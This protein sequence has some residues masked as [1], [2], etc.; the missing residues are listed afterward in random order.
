VDEETSM[1]IQILSDTH[2]EFHEDEGKEFV[3]NLPVVG[4][5]LVV[6]GDFSMVGQLV[7]RLTELCA[8]FPHVV[9]VA[10]NHEYYHTRGRDE[11]NKALGKVGRRC[12]NFTWLNNTSA[13]IQGRRFV[14]T[15]MW[16]PHHPLN[17]CHEHLLADFKYIRGYRKWVYDANDRAKAFLE[18]EV[19]PGDIVVTHHV[20]SYACIDGRFRGDDANR[21]YVS[22]WA[23]RIIYEQEPELWVFGHSHARTD[24][25][26]E[27]THLVSN[28]FGYKGRSEVREFD[29]GFVIEVETK[30]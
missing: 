16:F 5:V 22:G 25:L 14:G 18:R 27:Q 30:P 3:A 23:E 7:V 17:I 4:D 8:R 26:I 28:P 24:G 20:P 21:F 12:E 19:E 1:K 9:Y 2:L 15:T 11:V 29:P 13:R 6:A 10:G